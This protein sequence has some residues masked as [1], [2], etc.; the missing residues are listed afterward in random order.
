MVAECRTGQNKL[1]ASYVQ[2][3]R[4][5]C[6]VRRSVPAAVLLQ[7]LGVLPLAVEWKRQALRFWSALTTLPETSI[8]KQ[9]AMDDLAAAQHSNLQNWAAG[10]LASAKQH[11]MALT[12]IDGS[13]MAAADEGA[14][15]A[16]AAA[17]A[18]LEQQEFVNMNPRI[19][20]SAGVKRTTYAAWFS[21]PGWAQGGEFWQL[22]LSDSRVGAAAAR[23]SEAPLGI[24]PVARG[25]RQV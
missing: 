23:C 9:A 15:A 3:M 25:D 1:E 7:E 6:G 2:T 13:M 20:L 17:A 16:A 14:I 5:L 11:G 8:F 19:A 4:E 24:A 22:E 18:A 12:G 21:R 10:L